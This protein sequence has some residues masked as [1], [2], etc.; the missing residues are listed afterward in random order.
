MHVRIADAIRNTQSAPIS[1]VSTTSNGDTVKSLRSTGNDA[2]ARA[3][4]RSATEPPKNSSSVSTDRQS[5]PP[6]S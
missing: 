2:A 5:A 3:A 6:A 4:C 1:R